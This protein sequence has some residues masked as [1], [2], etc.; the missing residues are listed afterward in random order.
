MLG[1]G[2]QAEDQRRRMN[3]KGLWNHLVSEYEKSRPKS[4]AHFE[5][6]TKFLIRGGSHTLRLF[7]PFPFYDVRCAGSSVEDLD[8]FRYVDFWQG[9]YTNILGHNP[10]AVTAALRDLFA[11]GQ[12]LQTGFPSHRQVELAEEICRR[13]GAERVRLTS[14]GALATLYSVMLSRGFTGRFKVLKAGGGWHGAQPY[15]MK[16]VTK[17]VEC[18][19]LDGAETLGLHEGFE[20][21]TLTTR[22]ND[23]NDLEDVFRREGDALAC[24][25]VEPFIGEG[26]FLFADPDYLRLARSLTDKYGALLIFDEVISGFRFCANSLAW[27]YQIRP[28]L[29][30][31]GK[32]VGG[33][34]PIAAVAGRADVLA[35]CDPAAGPRRVKFEGGTYSAHPASL[36]AGLA[37]L[38]FIE[39]HE[40]VLYEQIGQLAERARQ[41]IEEIFRRNGIAAHCTGFANKV[42]PS[43][44][45]SMV[46]FLLKD[47]PCTTPEEIW[48][49]NFCDPEMREK[50]FKLAMINR[51]FFPAHGLG[52][53]SFAHTQGEIDRM[54][55]AVEDVAR[56]MK[57]F[58]F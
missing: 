15:L 5:R 19:G 54:L 55:E 7:E 4:R 39:Q 27:L 11:A 38:A 31:F 25:I 24:F 23:A 50:V 52:S 9:H 26:G 45:M 32:L 35:L 43:S 18:V 58:G 48:N 36:V 21:G 6:A 44:S 17:F 37:M 1:G 12:G 13:T 28:D 33:G 56:L 41:G 40:R 53:V 14:S 22:Y 16:G 57:K 10:E 34:M 47:R 30:T 49:P 42:V 51:G 3:K 8:G 2:R 46:H 20:S 29:S